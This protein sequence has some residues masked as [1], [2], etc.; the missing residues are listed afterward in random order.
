[1][2]YR[3]SLALVIGVLFMPV[4]A[5]PACYIAS[6][7]QGSSVRQVDNFKLEPGGFTGKEFQLQFNGENSSVSS[8]DLGC[9]Q[10]GAYTLLCL[11]SGIE[12][13]AV[14]ETWSVYPSEGVVVHTKIINGHGKFNGGQV[15]TGILKGLCK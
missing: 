6:G 4:A 8:S 9:L 7:F 11:N 14:I 12:A 3:N 1:M 5:F 2:Q 10:V 13:Q 15:F